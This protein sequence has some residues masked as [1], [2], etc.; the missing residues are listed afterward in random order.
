MTNSVLVPSFVRMYMDK[1]QLKKCHIRNFYFLALLS[2]SDSRLNYNCHS[3]YILC[4]K[5]IA[6]TILFCSV[7]RIYANK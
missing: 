5:E 6:N 2:T 7:C 1:L 4:Y 3:A